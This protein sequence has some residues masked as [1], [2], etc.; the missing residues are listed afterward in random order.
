MAALDRGW[1][2]DEA[3]AL[4]RRRRSPWEPGNDAFTSYLSAG[5]D[6]AALLVGPD[7]LG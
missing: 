2:V 5:L 1:P 3:V 6:V 4:V 7:P